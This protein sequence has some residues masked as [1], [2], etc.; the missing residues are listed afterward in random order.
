MDLCSEGWEGGVDMSIIFAT[1]GGGMMGRT[2]NFIFGNCL[3]G[4]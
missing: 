4:G 3:G 2:K 1:S